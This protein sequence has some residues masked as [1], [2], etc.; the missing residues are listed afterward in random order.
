MENADVIAFSPDGRYV[1]TGS[2]EQSA[3]VWQLP[4]MQEVAFLMHN[5]PVTALAFS[6]SGHY[7]ATVGA[8]GTVR[9][10]KLSRD[11]DA[12]RP[13][14]TEV[15]RMVHDTTVKKIAFS[16]DEE[17]VV[18][19]SKDNTISVWGIRDLREVISLDHTVAVFNV[20]FSPDGKFLATRSP[21]DYLGSTEEHSWEIPSGKEIFEVVGAAGQ[22]VKPRLI[23]E[24]WLP[25][26][27]APRKSAKSEDGRFETMADSKNT[28]RVYRAT[29]HSGNRSSRSVV[30]EIPLVHT[31]QGIALSPDGS[32]LATVTEH[33]TARIWKVSNGREM[34]R[35]THE[36]PNITDVAFSPHDGKYVATA[37][38]D[39]TA[40]LWLWRPTDLIAEACSRLTRN[41]TDEELKQ[42]LGTMSHTP[43]CALIEK[44]G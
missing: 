14:G 40:R 7:L 22:K 43:A 6:S 27:T 34:A 37:S 10:W 3:R 21:G 11:K 13:F 23:A 1:A 9:V 15:A 26:S 5:T 33:D 41:L 2:P 30:A 17:H 39:G 29:S 25:N 16:P 31:I 42:Y 28:V 18:T 35:L 8:N 36:G 4:S 24:Q 38:W 44:G 32:F 19:A 12:A 20:G